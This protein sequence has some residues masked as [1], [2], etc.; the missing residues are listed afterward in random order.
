MR[1]AALALALVLSASA[2]AQ[3]ES[4][5][6]QVRALRAAGQID[7]AVQ[8]LEELRANPAGLSPRTSSSSRWSWPA[9]AWKR[10]AGRPRTA[11]GAT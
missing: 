3:K 7:Q 10:R 9:P 8:K 11:V 1:R 2:L 4:P 6:Y 5:L